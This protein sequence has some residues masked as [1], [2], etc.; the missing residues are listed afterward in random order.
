LHRR[1]LAVCRIGRVHLLAVLPIYFKKIPPTAQAE[2]KQVLQVASALQHTRD[3]NVA[4]TL[5]KA[6]AT[7]DN[8]QNGV[9][10]VSELN[11]VRGRFRFVLFLWVFFMF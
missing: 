10:R 2:L 1:A 5:Q 6:L 4:K 7:F 8:E 11:H 3:T 9:V